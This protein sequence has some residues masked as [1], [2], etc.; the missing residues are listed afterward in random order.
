MPAPHAAHSASPVTSTLG[1]ANMKTSILVALLA[2]VA[3]Y[4]KAADI[5]VT[6][7]VLQSGFFA[8]RFTEDPMIGSPAWLVSAEIQNK[9]S[10]PTEIAFMSCSWHHSFR[11]EPSV[12]FLVPGWGCT[13]NFPSSKLLAPGEKILFRFPVI[14][15][16]GA[17]FTEGTR[18]KIGF[19]LQKLRPRDHWKDGESF[20]S[21]HAM[22]WS[23]EMRIPKPGALSI[24]AQGEIEKANGEIE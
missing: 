16:K 5:S 12:V 24:K 18:L 7:K 15:K 22:V 14:M 2:F 8:G 19:L 10:K 11:L 1:S 3:A 9:A 23:E 17:Q 20:E 21:D 6:A 13:V 4:T